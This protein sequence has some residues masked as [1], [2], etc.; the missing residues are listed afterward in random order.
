MSPGLPSHR[1]LTAASS[2]ARS[3]SQ[4]EQH[5]A[6][7]KLQRRQRGNSARAVYSVARDVRDEEARRE[8]VAFHLAAGEFAEARALMM[9]AEEESVVA[10]AA[11]R[12]QAAARGGAVRAVF[13][14]VRDAERA[15][16]WFEYYVASGDLDS[17]RG[18]AV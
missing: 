11:A 15:R 18:M 7:I 5:R 9:A 2:P 6:A 3:L 4:Q 1:L 17:A 14:D 8:W 12:I 10:A 13:R 16:R